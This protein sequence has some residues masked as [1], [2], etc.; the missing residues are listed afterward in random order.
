MAELLDMFPDSPE[1]ERARFLRARKGKVSEAA[2][3][4]RAHLEWREASLPPPAGAP[5]LGKGLPKWN[6]MD[7]SLGMKGVDG[8][9]I[10]LTLAALCDP[11]VG[12]PAEYAF[13]A[14]VLLDPL[15]G[16]L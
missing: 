15:A 3:M 11:T 1:A 8:E 16:Y 4:L 5:L 6:V 14:A 13:A 12:T 9:P 7:D 10:L 2:A